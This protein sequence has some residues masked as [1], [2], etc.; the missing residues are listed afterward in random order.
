MDGIDYYGF[1]IVNI[2]HGLRPDVFNVQGTTPGSNGFDA[3]HGDRRDEHQHLHAGDEQRLRVVERRPR[4]GLLERRSDFLTGNLDDVRGALNLD[5][6]TG[7]HRLFIS[8]EAASL[9][10]AERPHHRPVAPAFA[11]GLSPSAEIWITRPGAGRG[12]RTRSTAG[13]A[14]NL[15]DGVDYWTGSG[16]DTIFDRRHAQPRAASA[17]RR[18]SN[19]GLG[20]RQRHGHLD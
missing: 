17:R 8:D 6:G 12:S 1:E 18:S 14:N 13:P 3:R 5:L 11:T 9:G 15:F 19:T 2:R 16:D 20:E 4:R 7:R 10:D